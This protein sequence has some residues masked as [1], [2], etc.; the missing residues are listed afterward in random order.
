MSWKF[1]LNYATKF[2]SILHDKGS[3][4]Q[5]SST[6]VSSHTISILQS[7][8]PSFYWFFPRWL[9]QM[10]EYDWMKL[11]KNGM[12]SERNF[13]APG[14]ETATIF[15]RIKHL[16]QH[17]T[18]ERRTNNSIA[19]ISY[20]SPPTR[21]FLPSSELYLELVF[22]LDDVVSSINF[23]RFRTEINISS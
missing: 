14:I 13:I 6:A 19:S 18:F 22:H 9:L 15:Q 1:L 3:C 20:H 17:I 11:K 10:L 16:E 5:S 4:I 21:H 23:T 8:F 12:S 2:I 7:D